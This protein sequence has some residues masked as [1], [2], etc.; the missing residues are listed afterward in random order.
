MEDLKE[1]N[2]TLWRKT[3]PKLVF[4]GFA[5]L[6]KDHSPKIPKVISSISPPHSSFLLFKNP[7]AKCQ[8]Q[9]LFQKKAK[10]LENKAGLKKS[11][12]I[13]KSKLLEILQQEWK[14]EVCY[15]GQNFPLGGSCLDTWT[16]FPMIQFLLR[17]NI[18]NWKLCSRSA[19]NQF[20]VPVQFK[21]PF[22]ML[23][24]LLHHSVSDAQT[25]HIYRCWWYETFQ[26]YAMRFQNSCLI[27]YTSRCVK[28]SRMIPCME[29]L[30]RPAV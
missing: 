5:S 6:F 3:V 1:K 23:L 7:D 19:N 20:P 28:Q 25:H 13:K 11:A 30:I 17:L 12:V 24:A 29:P 14:V 10:L 2:K 21:F 16:I 27:I 4:W 15:M 9:Y 26:C 18:L 22:S 8:N